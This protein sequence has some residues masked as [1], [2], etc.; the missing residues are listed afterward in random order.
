MIRSFEFVSVIEQK[1]SYLKNTPRAILFSELKVRIA[2][3][4]LPKKEVYKYINFIIEL[5]GTSA[6]YLQAIQTLS[7]TIVDSYP[8]RHQKPILKYFYNTVYQRF[9]SSTNA[10]I[11]YA[12]EPFLDAKER[13]IFKSA[14]TALDSL[15]VIYDTSENDNKLSMMI[16]V[17]SVSPFAYTIIII[18]MANAMQEPIFGKFMSLIDK[19]GQKPPPMIGGV[20]AF[21]DFLI[22]TQILYIPL[23]IMML[24]TYK[25]SLPNMYGKVRMGL[26]KVPLFGLPFKLSR[27]VN[28]ALFLN[29]LSLLY[30]NG[31][32]TK[33]ALGIIEKSSTRFMKHHVNEMIQIHKIAG[34]DV[35]SLQND[36]FS[37]EINHILSI[38]FRVTDPTSHM[39]KISQ[40]IVSALEGKVR[41]IAVGI[42]VLGSVLLTLYLLFISLAMMELQNVVQQ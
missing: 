30:K 21:N 11:F 40:N 15:K 2:I 19:L 4:L 22:S 36:L 28:A 7:E 20:Y 3:A 39:D 14:P 5:V 26:E 38:F 23:T 29:S 41:F 42:N 27:D 17:A 9:V 32:N 16:R 34:S 18:L 10:D 12:I 33:R 37:R 24:I 25:Y 6:N 1:L 31:I 13:M 8:K 35:K